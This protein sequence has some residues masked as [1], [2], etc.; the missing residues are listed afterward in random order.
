MTT[1]ARTC[2]PQRRRVGDAMLASRPRLYANG[3]L[4]LAVAGTWGYLLLARESPVP[5]SADFASVPVQPPPGLLGVRSFNGVSTGRLDVPKL[6]AWCR[7][8]GLPDPPEMHTTEPAVARVLIDAMYEAARKHDAASYG[9]AGRV[10][11]SIQCDRAAEAYFLRATERASGDF[12]WKYYLGCLAQDAGRDKEALQWFKDAVGIE[13]EYATTYARMGQIHLNSS[14]IEEARDAFERYVGLRPDDWLGHVGLARVALAENNAAV[15][16]EHIRRAEQRRAD[17]FQVQ[18]YLGK[19]LA[20]MG[21]FERANEHFER[22]GRLPKGSWFR[23]RDPLLLE[24]DRLTN[25]TEALVAEFGRSRESG[26]WPALTA[27][28]EEIVGR[29][30]DDVT[31][32]GNLISLYRKQGRLDKADELLADAIAVQ[33]D[34]SRLFVLR[35]EV[36]FSHKQLDAAVASANEALATNS[37]ILGAYN[38]IGRARYLQERFGEAEAAMRE[39]VA[40]DPV[41][42]GKLLV[43]GEVLLAR[44]KRDEA[45][46]V[47]R[48]VL[49]IVPNHSVAQSR[50]ALVSAQGR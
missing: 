17:D 9:L 25:S 45:A 7:T 14:N 27:L 2:R 22:A 8:Y 50:L 11:E 33:P 46:D 16:S 48:R 32:I 49:G 4:F 23:T 41:N 44:D 10:L 47:Y 43:L 30:P 18:Y 3:L 38:V 26:D 15:A 39:A 21:R 19:T 24:S 5:V 34:S 31:M 40:R 20:A 12:R 13:P 35:A 6:R 42:A 37:R 29:R 28:A 36:L 1:H